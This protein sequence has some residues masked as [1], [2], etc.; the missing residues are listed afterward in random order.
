MNVSH[1]F[2]IL[3]VNYFLSSV[4]VLFG[5]TIAVMKKVK[6]N[7]IFA[8]ISGLVNIGLNLIL[9]QNYGSAG[10]A[11][12]TVTVTSLIIV[13]QVIFFITFYKKTQRENRL[14]DGGLNEQ[15]P[16]NK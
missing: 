8:V 4:K 3:G 16:D 6:M 11:A 5:N 2:R 9:I 13:M 12:A 1:I 10:A 14:A 15:D 7:L